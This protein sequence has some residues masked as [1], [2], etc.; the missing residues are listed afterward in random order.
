MNLNIAVYGLKT[1]STTSLLQK[2]ILLARK[3]AASTEVFW[4]TKNNRFAHQTQSSSLG[5]SKN[6]KLLLRLSIFCLASL[7]R[8]CCKYYG[9]RMHR[10]LTCATFTAVS[11][12]LI[13]FMYC[14]YCKKNLT[15][16]FLLIKFLDLL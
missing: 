11:S 15:S 10:C 6:H 7:M 12:K 2:E 9:L 4:R 5:F 13:S 14:L 8:V 3:S 1:T 16:Q